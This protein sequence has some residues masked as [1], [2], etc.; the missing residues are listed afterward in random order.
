MTRR[1][2]L[3][4]ILAAIAR[5]WLRLTGAPEAIPAARL[6][7]LLRVV[8]E[9]LYDTEIVSGGATYQLS[10]FSS[11]G[12]W[13]ITGT[14]H[15]PWRESTGRTD[16]VGIHPRLAGRT[17]KRKSA[18][19]VACI[20]CYRQPVENICENR[21]RSPPCARPQ[22]DAVGAVYSTRYCIGL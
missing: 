7:S 15:W 21:C 22:P 9:P 18:W 5:W 4:L 8:T 10:Y 13:G 11:K 19:R 16:I 1:E 6:G 20:P 17:R 3:L 12:I 14:G 2:F